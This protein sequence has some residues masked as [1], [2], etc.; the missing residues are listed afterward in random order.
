MQVHVMI[1]Y[2]KSD[3]GAGEIVQAVGVYRDPDRA[4]SEGRNATKFNLGSRVYVAEVE[5]DGEALR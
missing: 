1:A 2:R 4:A 3:A 5:I